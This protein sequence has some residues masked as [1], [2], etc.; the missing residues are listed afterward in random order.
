VLSFTSI[1]APAYEHID[2][3][4]LSLDDLLEVE[5]YSV[6]RGRQ[7]LADAPAA[8]YVITREEIRRSGVT[9][10]PDAFRLIPGME[11]ARIDANKWA[12]TARGYNSRFANKLLVLIDG[13]TVYTPI[14]SGVYWDMHDIPLE[15]VERIEVIR[16]PG[17]SLWGANAVNGIISI[18]TAPA[19]ATRGGFV[20]LATGTD[21][22]GVGTVRY[23]G[24][25]G[26]RAHYRVTA[27]YFDHDRFQN[28]GGG[29]AFDAWYNN[30]GAVRVDWQASP[31]DAVTLHAGLVDG[32]LEQAGTP[33]TT[34]DPPTTQLRMTRT[35][36]SAGHV[37]VRWER[38]LPDN[39]HATLQV[40]YDRYERL[41]EALDEAVRTADVDF[42]H[43]LPRGRHQLTWGLG[44]RRIHDEVRGGNT[45][46]FHPVARGHDLLSAFAQDE[47][48]LTP[49]I[50]LTL[51]TKVE[52]NDFS[53]MEIQPSVRAMWHP[54]PRHA[55]WV[56]GSRA[57]RTPSRID[58]DVEARLDPTVFLPT[59]PLDPGNAVVAVSGNEA[60]TSEEL[61][62]LE[63]GYRAL[64]APWLLLDAAAYYHRYDKLRTLRP[65]GFRTELEPP[66]GH[67]VFAFE[68]VSAMKGS[69]RGIEV[70]AD[71][72][73]VA[74]W[75]ARLTYRWQRIDMESEMVFTAQ[76]V[77]G[78]SAEQQLG[79]N[80][81]VDLTRHFEVD[82]SL[83]YVGDLPYLGIESYVSANLRLGWRPR[84]ALELYVAGHDLLGSSH[85]EYR[86]ENM[87]TPAVEVPR[88]AH[89]GLRWRF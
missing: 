70:A 54:T 61:L 76:Q 78:L 45:L 6:S 28:A 33:V 27:R 30:R 72:Q 69:A 84:H 55:L 24:Q 56:A 29:E 39:A 3:T 22:R 12:T 89:L 20:A 37:Q 51:G 83:R 32:Q 26:A 25:L 43:R 75:R 47:I 15:D 1:A 17:A 4:S 82:A 41:E 48:E 16:G 52:R 21:E 2:L 66:P 58:E 85:M 65:A 36:V 80:S 40:Y 60:F 5:V 57:A 79:V 46:W 35:P 42:M 7:R 63:V 14:H 23:A 73:V 81:M 9:S 88:H 67:T 19:S 38:S 34:L 13:R 74:P 77:E 31:A 44:Y 86:T 11:V 64:P 10:L 68:M 49:Q 50:E 18:V 53:G 87:I 8:V 71:W 62:A 59:L